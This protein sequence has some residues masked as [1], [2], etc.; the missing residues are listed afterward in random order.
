M[1]R[2]LS[3]VT[4]LCLSLPGS[5]EEPLSEYL[6]NI[7][8]TIRAGNSEGSGVMTD[9]DK[10]TWI[11]TAGHVVAGLRTVKE[12]V[13]PRTGA[14]RKI[15]E[16]EDAQIVRDL[17]Q[18]GRKVGEMKFLA[19]VI[20]FSTSEKGGQDIAVLRARK[21][22]LATHPVKF[23]LDDKIPEL[24]TDLYHVGSLLGQGGSNS[25]TSGIY[26]QVGR[27]HENQVY[28]QTSCAA[29]PGSSGGGVF[30]KADGR[31]IGMVVR[32]GG[33]TFNL[34]VPIRRLREWSKKQ[35][36]DWILDGNAKVPA[37]AEWRKR[38]IE[39]IGAPFPAD[40]MPDAK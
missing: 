21:K 22:G 1:R 39:D 31:Y 10:T 5:A 23:F 37:D 16:F 38:P 26:S 2:S 33:E 19:E 18:D 24:G 11:I 15:V 29:F 30:L 6:Q 35:G 14:V 40:K 13:D 25:M 3:L 7:S 8:C 28:D 36:L 4:L 32:G 17:Y 34:I 12:V 20:R 27:L 9:R